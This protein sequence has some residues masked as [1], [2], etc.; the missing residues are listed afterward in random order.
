MTQL[1]GEQSSDQAKFRITVD[2]E[3]RVHGWC[4]ESADPQFQVGTT[5]VVFTGAHCRLSNMSEEGRWIE[6]EKFVVNGK[7][8]IRLA[9]R[10]VP[11]NFAQSLRALRPGTGQRAHSRSHFA[12]RSFRNLWESLG[13][14]RNLYN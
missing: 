14:L 6:T 5:S 10:Q 1:R 4:S 7:E 11:E 3:Q 9:G 12:S 8:I 13:I 2:L